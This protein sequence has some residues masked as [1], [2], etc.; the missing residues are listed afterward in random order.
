[1]QQ[2]GN[3]EMM[4]GLLISLMLISTPTIAQEIDLSHIFD[5][6]KSRVQ[7]INEFG[8]Y[9]TEDTDLTFQY[10]S[11][12]EYK[13]IDNVKALFVLNA[14]QSIQD[15]ELSLSYTLAVNYLF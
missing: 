10:K 12:I 13:V 7:Y 14:S 8:Y 1:M 3:K 5:G 15:T 4:R 11:S 2:V 6:A 9:A